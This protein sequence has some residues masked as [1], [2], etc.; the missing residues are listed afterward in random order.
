[1]R[2]YDTAVVD[3]DLGCV[4]AGHSRLARW[5]YTAL[6]SWLRIAERAGKRARLP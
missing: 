5:S 2:A 4:I 3:R 6:A 1:L